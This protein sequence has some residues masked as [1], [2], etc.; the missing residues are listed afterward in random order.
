MAPKYNEDAEEDD[1]D[2]KEEM[3][4]TGS[5]QDMDEKCPSNNESV[6]N[7]VQAYDKHLGRKKA[8]HLGPM[9]HVSQS[10]GRRWCMY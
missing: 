8:S 3:E 7:Y 5:E 1:T 6:S 10:Q 2:D 4:T 9:S